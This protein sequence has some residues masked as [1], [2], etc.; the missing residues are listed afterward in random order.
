MSTAE[1]KVSGDFFP[2]LT[3]EPVPTVHVEVFANNKQE[4]ADGVV[5]KGE[6]TSLFKM[7]IANLLGILNDLLHASSPPEHPNGR[8]GVR[9]YNKK[10]RQWCVDMGLAWPEG[11]MPMAH[12]MLGEMHTLNTHSGM[13]FPKN[14]GL[15][16]TLIRDLS[17]RD[18]V[19]CAEH[20]CEQKEKQSSVESVPLMLKSGETEPNE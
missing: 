18:F 17:R 9:V 1:D 13:L 12:D 20:H 19:A 11:H 8:K 2:K 4:E 10:A 15:I 5:T 16:M 3:V 14:V 6:P 7:P